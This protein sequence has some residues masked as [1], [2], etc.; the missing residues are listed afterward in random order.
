MSLIK[1]LQGET[2]KKA[3][4]IWFELLPCLSAWIE[5][6]WKPLRKYIGISYVQ[7]QLILWQ[8]VENRFSQCFNFFL[9]LK[10]I[11][12]DNDFEGITQL[13]LVD[14]MTGTVT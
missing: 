1:A 12:I 7:R 9:M 10:F 13:P 2:W 3:H 6:S 5:G 14:K 4:P 8:D 11:Y